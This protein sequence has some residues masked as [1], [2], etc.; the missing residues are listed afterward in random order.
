[1]VEAL[2][3]ERNAQ[4]REARAAGDS[5]D[6]ARMLE[7]DES[8]FVSTVGHGQSKGGGAGYESDEDMLDGFGSDWEEDVPSTNWFARAE[9]ASHTG[10]QLEELY[11]EESLMDIKSRV[12]AFE[13]AHDAMFPLP[14]GTPLLRCSTFIDADASCTHAL[15]FQEM[16]PEAWAA[17]A[18]E[19]QQ[20]HWSDPLHLRKLEEELQA[21]HAREH[22]ARRAALRDVESG[23]DNDA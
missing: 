7:G 3:V 21:P 2:L 22:D 17:M 9:R 20:G 5:V 1:M 16:E 11:F 6:F 12:Y 23:S 19:H 10:V 8:V 14:V 13:T 18:R 15:F 4:I